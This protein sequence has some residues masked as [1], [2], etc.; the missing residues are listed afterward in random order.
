MLDA[1]LQLLDK[2]KHHHN[3]LQTSEKICAPVPGPPCT[4]ALYA[5]R[6]GRKGWGEEVT[7]P[8]CDPPQMPLAPE[9]GPFMSSKQQQPSPG[10]FIA[11]FSVLCIAVLLLETQRK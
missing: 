11:M 9:R 2:G 3:R 10:E 8:G 4:G 5:V 7:C 1:D 6:K